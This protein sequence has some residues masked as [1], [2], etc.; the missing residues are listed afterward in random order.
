MTVMR[1][2]P[3]H[4]AVGSSLVKETGQ[5]GIYKYKRRRHTSEGSADLL[6]VEAMVLFEDERHGA[7]LEVQNSPT[8]GDPEG[9]EE[10]DWLGNEHIYLRQYLAIHNWGGGRTYGKVDTA[11]C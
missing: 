2:A 10:D 4:I 5:T 1:R 3:T 11:K 7:E 6:N 8:E 9:E